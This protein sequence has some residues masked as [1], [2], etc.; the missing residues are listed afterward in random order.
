MCNVKIQTKYI[1]EKPKILNKKRKIQRVFHNENYLSKLLTL[2]FNLLFSCCCLFL[3]FTI[4]EYCA[5]CLSISF[6]I[7]KSVHHFPS[8]NVEIRSWCRTESSNNNV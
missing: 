4:K 3:F 8:S 7:V 1:D 5:I 6:G 2:E